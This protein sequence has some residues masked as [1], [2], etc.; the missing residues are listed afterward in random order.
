[1]VGTDYK[2]YWIQN[3]DFEYDI[4]ECLWAN[5]QFINI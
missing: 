2:S 3:W 1:M 4:Q 5:M